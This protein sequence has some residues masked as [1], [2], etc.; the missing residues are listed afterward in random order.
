MQPIVVL[1]DDIP[2][3][4]ENK[5]VTFLLRAGPYDMNK[6]A[7]MPFSKEDWEQFAQLIGYSVCGF[8]ELSYVSDEAVERAGKEVEKLMSSAQDKNIK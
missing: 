2:R 6:L 3:F 5:I 7:L 8:E 4:K 1:D